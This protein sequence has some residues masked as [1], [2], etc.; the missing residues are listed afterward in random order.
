LN[1]I[2]ITAVANKLTIGMVFKY[3]K[4][5]KRSIKTINSGSIRTVVDELRTD[6]KDEPRLNSDFCFEL[7]SIQNKI[8][9]FL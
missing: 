7:S 4:L 1:N 2:K 5:K 6:V 9:F 8:K 3:V